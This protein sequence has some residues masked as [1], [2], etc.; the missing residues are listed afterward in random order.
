MIAR[1]W[2]TTVRPGSEAA[3][4]EYA[5]TRSQPMFAA[6]DGCHGVLF[7]KGDA[8]ELIVCSL[9]RDEAAIAALNES[10]I[11]GETVAGIEALGILTGT[12]AVHL[13]FVEGGFLDLDEANLWQLRP[14]RAQ[15]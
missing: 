2:T 8:G 10:A 3:Y 4:F 1:F 15:R 7:L 6:A 13:A 12:P 5:R 14:S 11:Y 9:W